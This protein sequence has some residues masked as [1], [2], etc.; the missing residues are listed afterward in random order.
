MVCFSYILK[1]FSY[2][3]SSCFSSIKTIKCKG[4]ADDS[5]MWSMQIA[6]LLKQFPQVTIVANAVVVATAAA[7]TTTTTT[8]TTSAATTTTTTAAAATATSST[9]ATS[10]PSATEMLLQ[11]APPPPLL[12]PLL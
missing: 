1:R 12:Q 4:K 5:K 6:F 7:T 9:T 3:F 10:A 8:T 2:S 11:L